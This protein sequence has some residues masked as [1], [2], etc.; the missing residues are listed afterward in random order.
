MKLRTGL[1]FVLLMVFTLYTFALNV[2]D[3]TYSHLGKAE[4]MDNQ[5]IFSLCQTKSGAIWWSSK[6]SIGRYNGSN[7]QSYRLDNGTPYGNLGGRVIK[8]VCNDQAIYAFD[9][10]GS[11]YVYNANQDRF[12]FMTSIAKSVGHDVALND[13]CPTSEGIF[14][15]MHDGVWLLKDNKPQRLFQSNYVNNIIRIKERL[16]FCSRGGVYNRQGVRLLPYNIECGYYDELSG[17]IWLGGY[18]NGLNLVT[19]DDNGRVIHDTFV[20]LMGIIRQNPIRS[21]CP[22]DDNTML[23]GIDGQGVY[24]MRRDGQGQGTLLFDANESAYGVLHGNGVYCLLVDQWQNILVGTYSGGIDIAR[25][26]GSTAAIYNHIANNQQSL[27]NDHVNTV[28]PLS[29]KQLLMGTDNGISILNTK[30]GEWQHCCQGTVAISTTKKPDGSVL[31]TTYGKGVYEID[32]HAK[33][34]QVYT[35][36][37]GLI[38]DDH[39]YAIFYDRDGSLWVGTLMGDLLQK[40]KDGVYYYP[41]HDVQSITQLASG[42]IAVGTAFGLKFITPETHE[43]KEPN[44]A[45]SGVKDVNPFVTHLLSRGLEL[46]I[47]TDG[48]GIYVYHLGKHESRQITKAN[49][50][51]SN[52]ISSLAVGDDGRIWVATEEG[53]AFIVPNEPM[54]AINVNYCYGL[55]REYSRAAV[56]NLPDGNILFGSTT[57]SL[58]IHPQDIQPIN[59][60]AKLY[61]KKVVCSTDQDETFNDRIHQMLDDGKIQLNYDQRTFDLYFESINMRN[62]YDLVYRYKVGNGEWSHPMDEQHIRFT[63]LEPGKHLL[64]LQCVSR[65]SDV[66]IDTKEL[67]IIIAQPWWNSWWMWCVY[68]ALVLLTFYG[69]WRIY[70]LH[71]KYMRLVLSSP[72]LNIDA[73]EPV[74]EQNTTTDANESS[75][76][77]PV[78]KEEQSAFI[79]KVTRIVAENLSDADFNIDRLCREMA[80]SRTLFYIK[81]KSY[82][83]NSPQDFI[84]VIRLERAASLLRSGRSVSDTATITGFDNAK[85]F[86]TV[87]KKYFGVS[88]SK[89]C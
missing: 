57:G 80:M 68:I 42:Q 9:N 87:F 76:S 82:T 23:I 62:H 2:K 83:G 40:T 26:I 18:E 64:T 43:V 44:Y 65:T 78:N 75:A 25:P 30:T 41:I 70:Q 46:W 53:L 48:G 16:L 10:R 71:T 37:D 28:M 14:L 7:I 1:T 61:L 89:F 19:T 6:T 85:Y 63:N 33:V 22:Y 81:L 73:I 5:R 88:P 20:P 52:H 8:M 4:G 60:T 29:D 51:P 11:I 55:N 72:S 77:E 36:A 56:A 79:E 66:V 3:F 32:S 24:Q 13:I 21:I 15:G 84:R 27:L 49:G 67:T 45:P 58:V 69:A 34:R 39:V 50:L 35:T 74:A 12:D 38:K 86:S 31:V 47:A 17:K 54:K 59:Y